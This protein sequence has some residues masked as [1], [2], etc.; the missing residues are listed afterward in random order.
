MAE[1][2]DA[3]GAVVKLQQ[4][5]AMVVE[6]MPIRV[7]EAIGM[8]GRALL[9]AGNVLAARA[10]L[11]LQASI[12]GSEDPRAM[13]LLAPL[14]RSPEVP[15]LLRDEQPLLDATGEAAE[16]QA[17]VALAIKGRWLESADQLANLAEQNAGS[18]VSPIVIGNLAILQSWLARVEEATDNWKKY[19]AL[20]SLDPDQAIEA[21]AIGFVS[22]FEKISSGGLPR[23][24]RKVDRTC[25]G[26]SAGV[27]D[28]NILS[29]PA[30][31]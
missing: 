19:A 10:H 9:A 11:L 7:Y 24:A 1:S 30:T 27:L 18:N 20:D 15:L 21:E 16:V 12:G 6:Q 14:I 3:R 26:V 13:S 23:S 8:V 4:S 2:E 22:N 25:S 31:R 5:L 29:S 28:C 17:A